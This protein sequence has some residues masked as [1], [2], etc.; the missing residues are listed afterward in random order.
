MRLTTVLP[1]RVRP[2]DFDRTRTW[3]SFS[4]WSQ[5]IGA[6]RGFDIRFGEKASWRI[7]ATLFAGL[8]L[9]LG[10]CGDDGV[11]SRFMLKPDRIIVERRPDPVYDQLFPYYIELCATS[12]FRSKLKGEGG[13]AGQHRP[14]GLI[15]RF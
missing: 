2:A 10:G 8:A 9:P 13:L 5:V 11:I 4:R 14:F 3:L 7:V 6:I 15:C 1:A 12:Q